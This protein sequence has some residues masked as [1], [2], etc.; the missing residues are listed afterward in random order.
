MSERGSFRMLGSSLV[1]PARMMST[2]GTGES[3]RTDGPDELPVPHA[4]PSGAVH[5]DPVLVVLEVLHNGAGLNPLKGVTASLIL[6]H[7]Y[8]I[9]GEGGECLSVLAEMS[10]GQGNLSLLH[11]EPPLLSG[12]VIV[13]QD[14]DKIPYGPPK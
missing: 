7:N 13:R 2:S 6:H 8:S 4:E 3:V 1:S 14:G 11:V 9:L 5:L 12:L 10:L